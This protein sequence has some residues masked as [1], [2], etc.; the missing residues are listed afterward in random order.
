M[1]L[2]QSRW[3]NLES[4][5]E[6]FAKEDE[7]G[8]EIAF[9]FP[10]VRTRGSIVLLLRG[11]RRYRM[12]PDQLEQQLAK[13]WEEERGRVG[14]VEG[15]NS[16][17][18]GVLTGL[19][20]GE[21]RA[22][23]KSGLDTQ[24]TDCVVDSE[25]NSFLANFK[26]YVNR[27]DLL[28]RAELVLEKLQ[29]DLEC[30]VCWGTLKNPISL[31][32]G[33]SFCS[34]CISQWTKSKPS[35]PV[36]RCPTL[37]YRSYNENRA[38][39][40]LMNKLGLHS[41]EEQE[42]KMSPEQVLK[43]NEEFRYGVSHIDW[44]AELIPEELRETLL[45]QIRAFGRIRQSSDLDRFPWLS[46]IRIRFREREVVQNFQ[47][48]ARE[49]LL[50]NLRGN[51]RFHST[52]TIP[53]DTLMRDHIMR[54]VKIVHAQRQQETRNLLDEI[55]RTAPSASNE[56]ALEHLQQQESERTLQQIQLLGEIRLTYRRRT[57]IEAAEQAMYRQYYFPPP[58]SQNLLREFK[59]F[60]S[61]HQQ[62]KK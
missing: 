3:E 55:R 16:F 8:K 22:Q 39:K 57:A 53:D 7:D 9:A 25:N 34:A 48:Q 10:V 49:E 27:E 31:Q 52:S 40:S 26:G 33:H 30:S 24:S 43:A 51:P 60:S 14:G 56:S 36:C 5:D 15:D 54:Q 42:S 2:N 17:V 45:N 19:L 18:A 62:H 35:C 12:E 50:A 37:S 47:Q 58:P 61:L 59:A 23:G 46:E 28:Q 1:N 13:N 21:M 6:V 20:L 29:D 44:D 11:R 32:C 4:V 41:A 38:L